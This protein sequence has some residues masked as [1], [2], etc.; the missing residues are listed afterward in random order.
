MMLYRGKNPL[1]KIIGFDQKEVQNKVSFIN[2]WVLDNTFETAT[3]KVNL[4]NFGYIKKHKFEEIIELKERFD[5]QLHFV[6]D[7]HLIKLKG[8]ESNVQRVKAEIHQIVD[9]L[10]TEKVTFIPSDHVEKEDLDSFK[11][12]IERDYEVSVKINYNKTEISIT[13]ENDCKWEDIKSEANNLKNSPRE[14]VII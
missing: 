1:I 14:W 10:R 5:I 8:N 2:K 4:D 7:G 6:K 9:N 3:I 12:E 11:T 13:G